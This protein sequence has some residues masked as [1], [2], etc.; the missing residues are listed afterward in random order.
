MVTPGSF[1]DRRG[2]QVRLVVLRVVATAI[3]GL[4]AVG[5]WVLQVVEHD[6]YKEMADNNYLRTIPLRAPRGVLFDRDGRVLVENRYSFTVAIIRE[7]SA[8]VDLAARRLAAAAGVDEALV[9]EIMQRHRRDPLF[10][11]IAVIEHATFAQVAAVMARRLELPEVVVQQVPTRAYPPDGF[12]AHLFG[13]VGEIQESQLDR[14]EYAGSASGAIVGQA[15]LEKIYNAKL[16]G[17]DGDRLVVV[18]SVGREINE[19]GEEPPV[20]GQRLQLTI[21]YDLQRALEEAFHA[22]GFAGAAVFLNPKTGEILAMTSQPAYDPNDFANGLERSKWAALNADPLNPLQNRLIQGRYQPGSTFKVL[23]A[24]AAL[25]EGII[26]PDFKA[27]CPGHAVFY[28]HDFKCDKKE[29]HGTLDL[30]HAIEQS[31]NVYFYTVGNMLKIDTI[32]EYAD[33]L[34]L[35][36]RT[37]IDL[38]GEVESLVPSTAWKLRTTGEKWYPGETISVAIGQGQVSVTPISLATMI[39]TVAN[40]G[41]VVTPHVVR[42]VDDGQG[43][44]I[45]APPPARSFFPIKPDVVQVVRDGLWLAVNGAGTASRARIDGRDV[46]GKTGTSQVISTEG[47]AAAAG[48]TLLDLRDNS[49]FEFFAPKD[50]AQ[51]AGV[52]FAEHAGHGGISSAPIARYVLETYFAKQDGKPLPTLP[53]SMVTASSAL[54]APTTPPAARLAGRGGGGQ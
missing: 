20:D 24:T 37:G 17:Q 1:E 10:S 8:N 54:A 6:K 33:K 32:K 38:P 7:R 42:A 46:S 39:T 28:G 14:P 27:F 18:N 23:I 29:G 2:L 53:A 3:F 25:S 41:T 4:L 49:W 5:F 31:C 19:V 30:R 12:A 44:Q 35:S 52:V 9:L 50:D 13:Y 26:T 51:I 36:G 21:D 43:W 16:M 22:G 40:G 34:G 11:P 15:G 47:R 48:K 45:V